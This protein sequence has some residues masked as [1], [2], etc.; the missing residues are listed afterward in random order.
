ME[1]RQSVDQVKSLTQESKDMFLLHSSVAHPEEAMT[2]MTWM[3]WGVIQNL[4][5]KAEEFWESW[6]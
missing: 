3:T 5:Y 4:K 1:V 2:W 6:Q